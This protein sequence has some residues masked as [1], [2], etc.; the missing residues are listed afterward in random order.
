MEGLGR[1]GSGLRDGGGKG[2][3]FRIILTL[4]WRVRTVGVLRRPGRSAAGEQNTHN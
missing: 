4:S 1:R 2:E 3:R